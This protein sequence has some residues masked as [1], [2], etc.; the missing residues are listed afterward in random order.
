MD[1]DIRNIYECA[2]KYG[3]KPFMFDSELIKK[4]IFN[5]DLSLNI[6]KYKKE[7]NKILKGYENE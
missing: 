6:K 2:S 1:R 3:M 7:A 4:N 5:V